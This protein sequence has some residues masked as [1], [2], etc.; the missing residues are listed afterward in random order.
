[1]M[2][3]FAI[4]QPVSRFEDPRLLRGGGRYVDDI[5][6]PQMAF[7]YVLR[8][9]HAHARIRSI[10]TSRAKAAPGVLAVLTGADWIASG[11][12]DLPV[13]GGNTRRDGSPMY[14][15]RYP[16]LASDRVR[17][18]GDYVAFVVAESRYQ[19]ADAAELIEVEYE[20]L[21]AVVSTA[22][23]ARA[24]APRVWDD[25]PDNICFVQTEG[26]RAATEAAFARADHVVRHRFV[27]NRVTAA[28][29]EPRGCIGHYD[30]AEGRYTLYT[31]LQRAHGYRSD[32][33]R[34]LKVPESKVRIVAGDIGG[35]FGMKSAVYNE[36]ALVLLASKLIGRPVKWTSTRSECF[37]ADAQA[38]DNVT[39]AELAL[40]K[41]GHFLA[42]RV[43]SFA[44]VGAYLQTGMPAFT[45]NLG[46]LAGVYRTPVAYVDVTAVFTHTPPVRPYRG[47]G[48]PEAAYVIERLVDLAAD[49]LGIDPAELRRRNYIPPE[50]MPFK[51]AVTFSYDS[52]EFEKNM[53]MAL[54]LADAAHFEERRAEARRRGKLRGLGLSNTIE[55][56]AAPGFEGVEIRFDRSG[57]VTL[58]AGSITQGQGH[59]TV[60]KQIVC[61]RLG[62]DP[63]DVHYVQ[64]DTDQVFFGEGTGG[65]RSATI[66]GSA[67]HI[68]A[69]RILA[70]AKRIAAH[71]LAVDETEINYADGVFSSPRTNRTLTIKE[72]AREAANPDRLPAGMEAGLI[73][74]AVY[75]APVQNF[76]NGCHVCELEID[77]ETG[78]VE[79]INYSVV[80]DV[81]TVLNPLLLHGQID[82]GIAQG[83]GQILMEDLRFDPAT[84]QLLTGSFMDYAVPRADDLCAF[85]VESNPVPTKTNP[86]GVKGAGE[87]G[88][89]GALPAVANALVDAL[90][91]LGIRHIEMPATPERLWRAI[92]QA[93]ERRGSPSSA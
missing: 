40:D 72:V 92:R 79:L 33:A 86:L 39:D 46:T 4:G 42:L 20:P 51:T 87:A 67:C 76:P 84:G 70:K 65:S 63:N 16:A 27:I 80:D 90:S 85:H 30:P 29:M 62:L 24:G 73:A 8:S 23:A 41:D 60:F 54:A 19:A 44:A 38:R 21:P 88:C 91:P 32:V 12:G 55:R 36:S 22:E 83:V 15:P 9:P 61:D 49:E 17:F 81:G 35:S 93:E 37:L 89:V 59:E 25:C 71:L 64:G 58:Y 75:N 1:M 5:V 57:T 13:P 3:E 82:G 74:T 69:E 18:V 14:R 7:G 45:G 10:D 2:G 78:T 53:D 6:L 66:G 56:A 77:P 11:W 31:T 48:R 26:D 43:T 52:G 68:A 47:N 50:A 28:T 34:I